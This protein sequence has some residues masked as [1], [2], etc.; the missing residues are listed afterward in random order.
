MINDHGVVSD[1]GTL[2]GT[3]SLARAVIRSG[4]V[5]GWAYPPGVA[6]QRAFLWRDGV[7][8]ELGTFRRRLERR[9]GHQRRG[10]IVGSSSNPD[11]TR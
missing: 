1:L 6:W 9:A 7:M 5:V 2:G 8:V 4:W 10:L 11:G 3:Q